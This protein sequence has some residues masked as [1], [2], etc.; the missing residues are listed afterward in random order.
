[1]FVAELIATNTNSAINRLKC[2]TI[3]LTTL[4]RK[5]GYSKLR[6]SKKN[7]P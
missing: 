3:N 2:L 1:M 6:N 7:T 4:G 5:H